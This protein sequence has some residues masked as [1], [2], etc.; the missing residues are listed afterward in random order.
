MKTRYFNNKFCDNLPNQVLFLFYNNKSTSY[1]RFYLK[2][3]LI[4]FCVQ[5]A[6]L[7]Q[8]QYSIFK[9]KKLIYIVNNIINYYIYVFNIVLIF[10]GFNVLIVAVLTCVTIFKVF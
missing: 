1:E 6:T 7:I 2:K 3:P 9:K 8:L 5:M 10:I 4:L